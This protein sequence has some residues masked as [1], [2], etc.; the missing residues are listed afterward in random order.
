M[1]QIFLR[2][3]KTLSSIRE[4]AVVAA[5]AGTGMVRSASSSSNADSIS[6]PVSIGIGNVPVKSHLLKSSSV[7]VIKKDVSGGE[8]M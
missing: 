2:F 8:Y 1:L 5:G 4:S 3:S 6:S 7:D